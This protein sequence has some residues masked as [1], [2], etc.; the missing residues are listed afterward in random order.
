M[1][2]APRA[3]AAS[4][5]SSTITPR[6]RRAR[7]PSGRVSNGREACSGSSLYSV[8]SAP[9]SAK[10]STSNQR[11]QRV[12]AAGDHHLRVA[13]LDAPERLAERVRGGGAGGADADHRALGAGQPRRS[14][15]ATMFWLSSSV[16]DGGEAVQL[17]ARRSRCSY[18]EHVRRAPAAPAGRRCRPIATPTARAARRSP[19]SMPGVARS[20]RPRPRRRSARRGAGSAPRRVRQL[21]RASKSVHDARRSAPGT[22]SASNVV[23]RVDADCRPRSDCHVLSASLPTGV[24]APMPV[25]DDAS[26]RRP[27]QRQSI[28]CSRFVSS[29]SA[30]SSASISAHMTSSPPARSRR[31]P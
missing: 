8:V 18:R 2:V 29:R 26:S 4:R 6:P 5:S 14:R 19:C 13:L 20:P 7:S 16:F 31:R 28:S 1:I 24:T 22:C 12:V 30:R 9:S 21:R 25:I 3:C 10:P 11:R 27:P 17:V 23:I 15:Q